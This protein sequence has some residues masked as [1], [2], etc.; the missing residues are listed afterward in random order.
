M[1]I[2]I[3]CAWFGAGFECL[4]FIDLASCEAAE[5]QV[6]AAVPVETSCEEIWVKPADWPEWFSPIPTPRP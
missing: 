4:P 3:L 1:T 6:R 2:A 5:R